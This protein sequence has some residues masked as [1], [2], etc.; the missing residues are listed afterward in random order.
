MQQR[1]RARAALGPR[2]NLRA[3][4]DVTLKPGAM[5]LTVLSGVVGEWIAAGG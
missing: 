4:H 1:E 5:P 2:F 3:F